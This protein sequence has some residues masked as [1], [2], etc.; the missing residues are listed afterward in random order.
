MAEDLGLEPAA[1]DETAPPRGGWLGLMA[2]AASSWLAWGLAGLGWWWDHDV[3]GKL[4]GRGETHTGVM[5]GMLAV[6]FAVVVVPMLFVSLFLGQ[7]RQRWRRCG[8]AAAVWLTGLVVP[9][10]FVVMLW[11]HS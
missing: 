8:W 9:V 5:C 10:G 11:L 3:T 4:A 1:R 6:G 2:L 7:P